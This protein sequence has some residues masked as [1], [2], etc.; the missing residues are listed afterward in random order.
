MGVIRGSLERMAEQC[1][2]EASGIDA[3]V[4]R[5]KTTGDIK[6]EKGEL[7]FKSG[8]CLG[9]WS[10]ERMEQVRTTLDAHLFRWLREHRTP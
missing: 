2:A 8:S 6:V 7:G 3:A 4:A 1:L 9:Q 5:I 10:P